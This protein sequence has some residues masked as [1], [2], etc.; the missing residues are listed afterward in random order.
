MHGERLHG[1]LRDRL[2]CLTRKT[3]AFAKTATT[4]D[5]L[6]GVAIF[7]HNWLRP[8]PALRQPTA[9]PGRRYEQRTPVMALGL[10]DHRWTWAEFLSMRTPVTPRQDLGDTGVQSP[11]AGKQVR[12]G[13][14]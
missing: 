11:L 8:H 14:G 2:A 4:W 1:V 5:A 10:A 13:A 9:V 12:C 3:H 7:E 6:V